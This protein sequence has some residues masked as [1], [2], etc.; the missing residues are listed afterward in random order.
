MFNFNI[1]KRHPKAFVAALIGHIIIA[2]LFT[3]SFEF[4][5]IPDTPQEVDVVQATAVDEAQV[6]AELA[7]LRRIDAERK[8]KE[9]ARVQKLETKAQQAE[10]KRRK[11]Q[12]RIAKLSEQRK[13][14]AQRKQE[15]ED[16]RK[17]AE[18]KHRQSLEQER[19]QAEAV[20]RKLEEERQA[21]EKQ[22][23]EA[24]EL[25]RKMREEAA[26]E[27]AAK[28]KEE[29]ERMLRDQ[30]AAE[31]REVAANSERMKSE[32]AKISEIFRQQ[33]QRNWNRPGTAK[34]GMQCVVKM[35]LLPNGDV[36]N[37]S[38]VKS[39]GDKVF[40]RSVET[41]VRKAAPFPMPKDTALRREVSD[42]TFVFNPTKK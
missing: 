18:E 10:D 4:T 27:L 32:I 20:K 23:R 35:R 39:S 36:I 1:I 11:E 6:Q 38:I 28:A 40:D 14:E 7:K 33:V 26:A 17:Q 2:V 30:L 8:A 16:A 42:L 34:E 5:Y 22:A 15:A 25:A 31:S 19:A 12:E 37:V 29:E 21:A 13:I 9:E 3:V 41:A 24:E